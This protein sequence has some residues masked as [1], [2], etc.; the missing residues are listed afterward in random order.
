MKHG[1]NLVVRLFVLILATVLLFIS[2]RIVYTLTADGLTDQMMGFE[3]E[4]SQGWT[5]WRWFYLK[6]SIWS[7]LGIAGILLAF[8]VLVA[9]SWIALVRD[10]RRK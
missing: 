1:I 6:R 8:A 7:I 2:A 5:Y 3:R 10:V 9:W 4:P